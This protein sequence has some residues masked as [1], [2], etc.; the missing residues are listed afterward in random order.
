MRR[1]CTPRG[2][3]LILAGVTLLALGCA[4]TPAASPGASPVTAAAAGAPPPIHTAQA[5]RGGAAGA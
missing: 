5:A 1:T 2:Q 4:R 3:A